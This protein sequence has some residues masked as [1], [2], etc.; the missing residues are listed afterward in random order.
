MKKKPLLLGAIVL[1]VVLGGAFVYYAVSPLFITLSTNEALPDAPK[2]TMEVSERVS[3]VDTPAHPAEG[4][5]RV[6]RTEE[7]SYIRY[8]DLKT[9]NGPDIFVYLAK[10]L[11]AKEFVSLGRVKSTEG[12]SNYPIPEGVNVEEYRYVLIWCKAFSVLFN[13]ADISAL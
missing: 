3:I 12:N 4:F 13:S 8:E 1:V 2:E 9:I 7:G 10:D 5:V 11:D 6:V